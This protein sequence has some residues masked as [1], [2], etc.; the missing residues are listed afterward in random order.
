[1]EFFIKTYQKINNKLYTIKGIYDTYNVMA[2]QTKIKRQILFKEISCLD[3][4]TQKR[5][6]FLGKE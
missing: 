3:S 2:T 1:M 5:N 4:L 6:Y